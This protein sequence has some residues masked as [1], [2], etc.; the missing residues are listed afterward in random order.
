MVRWVQYIVVAIII[1]IVIAYT[2]QSFVNGGRCT[3][4]IRFLRA[5]CFLFC[6]CVYDLLAMLFVRWILFR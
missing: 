4:F 2:Q 6:I 5:L 1:I 3:F